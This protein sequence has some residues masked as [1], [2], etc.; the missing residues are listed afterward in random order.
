MSVSVWPEVELT[1]EEADLEDV[2][3]DV[4]RVAHKHRKFS[5]AGQVI[6]V[7]CKGRTLRAVARGM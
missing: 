2:F 5:R 1:V 3:A 7:Y 6:L 4:I